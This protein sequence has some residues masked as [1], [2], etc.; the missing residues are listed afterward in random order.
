MLLINTLYMKAKWA[1]PFRADDTRDREFTAESG[2]TAMVPFLHSYG[3][4]AYLKGENFQGVVLPYRSGATQFIALKPEG[5]GARE[6]LESLDGEAI[7]AIAGSA[8]SRTVRLALPKI[9]VDFTMDMTD[10]LPSLG[11]ASAFDPDSADFSGMGTGA[12]GAPLYIGEVLQKVRITVDEEGTEAAAATMIGMKDATAFFPDEV[13]EL[14]FDQPFIY[15][16]VDAN[17]GAPLFMGL[18][19]ELS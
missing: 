6:L 9:D 12:G 18:V 5:V 11:L 1:K 14:A 10:T 4:T 19:T 15:L 8:S 3:R 16:I 2:R 13:I 7:A 17:C